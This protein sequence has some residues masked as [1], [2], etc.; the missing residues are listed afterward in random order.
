MTHADLIIKA[1]WIIPVNDSNDVLDNAALVVNKGKIIALGHQAE[2]D[3]QYTS[4]EIQTFSNHVL[5]PG[6]VNAHT[7]L[8]MSL[9]RGLADDLPLMTWLEKHIWPAERQHVSAGFVYDGSTLAIAEL[10]L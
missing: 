5:M 6:F 1:R 4:N 9:L 2:I 10:I 7:H 8:P 3:Q